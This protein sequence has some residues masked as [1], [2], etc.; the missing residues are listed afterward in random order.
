MKLASGSLVEAVVTLAAAGLMTFAGLTI[1]EELMV[2]S[3]GGTL[4][5]A[6]IVATPPPG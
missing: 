4:A 5:A 6:R 3:M 2:A 1:V